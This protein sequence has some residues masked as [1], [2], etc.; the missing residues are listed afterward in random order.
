VRDPHRRQEARAL[1]ARNNSSEV[2]H[3]YLKESIQQSDII[4]SRGN[5]EA[6]PTTAYPGAA[7]KHAAG[8]SA[9]A[10]QRASRTGRAR[11]PGGAA[12]RLGDLIEPRRQGREQS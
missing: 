9:S 11:L 12:G 6:N 7:A 4:A 1:G 5:C 8:R 2:E 3:L 10:T